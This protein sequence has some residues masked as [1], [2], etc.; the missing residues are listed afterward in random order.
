MVLLHAKYVEHTLYNLSLNN[1]IV[2]NFKGRCKFLFDS[3]IANKLKQRNHTHLPK[4]VFSS[5]PSAS[6]VLSYQG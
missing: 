3:V 2:Q 5:T 4:D 1:K 6:S